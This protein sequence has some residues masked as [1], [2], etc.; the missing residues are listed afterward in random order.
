MSLSKPDNPN[1]LHPN[2][3]RL[4]FD[5]LPNLEFFCQDIAL[6]GITSNSV[7]RPTPFVDLPSPGDKLVFDPLV[8]SILVDEDLNTWKELHRWIRDFTFPT[9]FEEYQDLRNIATGH[10]RDGFYQFSDA[11]LTLLSSSNNPVV[12]FKFADIYPE[13]V[14]TL[15][16][17]T[18]MSPDDVLVVNVV[19]RY[20]YFTIE[21][22]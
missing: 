6:P 5:R 10:I 16:L 9:T 11:N 21:S 13:S 1:L 17:S 12:S 19:F 4:K 22:L 15:Q 3:F 8:V 7:V 18:K 14:D 20:S 2:K